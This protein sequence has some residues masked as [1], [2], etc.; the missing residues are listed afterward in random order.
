MH[1]TVF[2]SMALEVG[3]RGRLASESQEMH[4]TVILFMVLEVPGW[5]AFGSR[6]TRNAWDCLHFHGF[7]SGLEGGGS[8]PQN[9]KTCIGLLSFS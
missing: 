8:W 5:G 9:H 3:G 7:G 4:R 2:I 6:I 1:R